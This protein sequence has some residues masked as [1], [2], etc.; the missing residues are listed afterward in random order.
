MRIVSSILCVFLFLSCG[1]NEEEKARSTE[2][3]GTTQT[4]IGKKGFFHLANEDER[5]W[6]IT[7]EGEKFVSLGINHIEP[8]LISSDNNKHIFME[9]YGKDLINPAGLPDNNSNAAKKWLDDSMKMIKTWGFNTLGLHNP[10][11]QSKMPYVAEFRPVTIDGWD[12]VK[13]EY[14]D[15]FDPETEHFVEQEAEKWCAQN[16]EDKF[17]LGISFNDMPKWRNPRKKPHEWVSFI[18]ELG[19]KAPGK[20][21]W[22]E[23][24]S[25][26]YPDISAAARAYHMEATTWNDFLARTSWKQGVDVK[27]VRRDTAV[28]L[29]IIA[30]SWYRIASNA[31]RKC[32]PNHLVFG[33]K[34]EGTRDFPRWLDPIIEKYFDLA[35]IQWYEYANKQ[36]PRLKELHK[37]TGKPILM[38]DSSFSFPNENLPTPKGLYVNSQREVGEAYH[39]YLKKMMNQPHVVGWHH[40]GFI[41]GSSDLKRVHFYFSIQNGFLRPDGTPYKDA[42]D[43]VEKANAKAFAWH[44]NAEPVKENQNHNLSADSTG[45]S[46]QADVQC[47]EKELANATMHKSGKNIFTVTNFKSVWPRGSSTKSISWVVTD[48]GAVVIDTGMN[49]SAQIAKP[50]I[51]STTD[52]P[53]KHI[54]YTHH[55]GTQVY[56]AEVIRDPE[57][58]VIAQED[59]VLEFDLMKELFRHNARRNSIQFNYDPRRNPDPNTLVY[60]DIT[61]KTEYKFS[62]GGTQFELYHVVGE[63]PDCTIIYLP[64][65]E[66]VWVGDLVGVGTPMV[67]SP[68]K[69][70]RN[71]VKWIKA[72]EFIK[73]LEPKIMIS[74][75]DKPLCD[76]NKINMRLDTQIAY[77][78]FLH[79]SVMRE[80]N[81]G[82]SVEEAVQ[83]IQLPAHAKSARILR[84]NYSSIKFNVRGLYHKYTGWFDENGSHLNPAPAKERAANFISD[85]GGGAEVLKK[86]D[87][88]NKEQNQKLALEYLDLL[89]DADDHTDEAHK[90]KSII[91]MAM[92]D[93]SSHFTSKRMY[94][95]LSKIESAKIT[96]K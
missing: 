80:L 31:I 25:K 95:R 51:D 44:E 87:N 28:F 2:T 62:L 64:E 13:K 26:I 76:K 56:G 78:G 71:E 52:K 75:I 19:P 32:D 20:K 91:L 55:H 58:K 60:P 14:L 41:E 93:E 23:V 6:F 66:I 35:Y 5:W 42:V 21:K 96:P 39:N 73:S 65:Q 1:R 18:A 4:I 30:E 49:E 77:L 46:G 43:L 47:S 15:P 86:A 10:I 7:P 8:V 81:I 70:V 67:A 17:I 9:K 34:F 50:I 83:N 33:D 40:C 11:K 12:G 84:E 69:R 29:P 72:L 57:T 79:K 68:R 89:I 90:L 54:I 88:L 22:V 92:S 94:R 3:T 37:T 24:L 27:K 74:A 48:E 82:S 45:R 63:A 53:I 85:M 59:L 38:G 36:I 61:Y 16:K